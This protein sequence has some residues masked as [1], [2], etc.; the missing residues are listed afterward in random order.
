MAV[1]QAALH[2]EDVYR[3]H[4]G[5]LQRIVAGSVTTSLENVED[6]CSF[7]WTQL[8]LHRLEAADAFGWLVTVA[9]RQAVKL[10]RRARRTHPIP[11]GEDGELFEPP[12]PRDV[13]DG[14]E[15]LIVAVDRLRAAKLTARQTRLLLLQAQGLTY[16]EIAALTGD[17]P[18]TVERQL[19]RAR[20]RIRQSHEEDEGSPDAAWR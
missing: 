6:A 15:R 8:I 3:R 20:L 13:I 9:V 12:D 5:Q 1:L 4:A 11:E 19:L 17:S 16:G 7:A 14:R 10:D 2:T 18:R